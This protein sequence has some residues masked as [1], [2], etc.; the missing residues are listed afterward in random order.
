MPSCI[1]P[2]ATLL[3]FPLLVVTCISADGLQHNS[4]SRTRT[5]DHKIIQWNRTNYREPQKCTAHSRIAR[6]LN[7]L[8]V[9]KKQLIH[10]VSASEMFPQLGRHAFAKRFQHILDESTLGIELEEVTSNALLKHPA[11]RFR[12]IVENSTS[13]LVGH[14]CSL[15][16]RRS[17]F[18]YI[19]S[20]HQRNTKGCHV[21]VSDLRRGPASGGRT[22]EHTENRSNAVH[23]KKDR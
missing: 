2:S 5:G 15:I 18:E 10:R 4:S 12:P 7:T 16:S 1:S 14:R 19:E 3:D 8:H 17:R 11:L 6:A 22:K 21:V 23:A 20:L 13:D 9:L